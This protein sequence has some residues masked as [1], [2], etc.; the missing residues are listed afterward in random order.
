MLIDIVRGI[1]EVKS[2]INNELKKLNEI[3]TSS[4]YS[5]DWER[6]W[7]IYESYRL[8]LLEKLEEIRAIDPFLSAEDE[9]AYLIEKLEDIEEFDERESEEKFKYFISSLPL[10]GGAE[11]RIKSEYFITE[12]EIEGKVKVRYEESVE[13]KTKAEDTRSLPQINIHP[14]TISEKPKPQ[15]LPQ[16]TEM[17]IIPKIPKYT[18]VLEELHQ[19]AEK[20]LPAVLGLNRPISDLQA[21]LNDIERELTNYLF[22]TVMKADKEILDDES[23]DIFSNFLKLEEIIKNRR[24]DSTLT[25]EDIR[26]LRE[27]SYKLKEY[28]RKKKLEEEI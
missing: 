26:M 19:L 22:G 3:D 6:L 5:S 23:K 9:I 24:K 25:E 2:A 20:S 13:V 27:F 18:K 15:S 7:R 1:R 11:G 28:V 21:V 4:M 10:I 12:E 8:K 14:P 16:K 17:E